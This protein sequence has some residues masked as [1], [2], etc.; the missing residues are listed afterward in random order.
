[1][2][3]IDTIKKDVPNFGEMFF[4]TETPDTYGRPQR[5]FSA[6]FVIPS[7]PRPRCIRTGGIFFVYKDLFQA[8]TNL[9]N[10]CSQ[11]KVS[12]HAGFWVLS[13]LSTII[14]IQTLN[15]RK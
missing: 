15:R 10:A 11:K 2:R 1:M 14:L 6:S 8:T 3:D 7:L 12:V 4:E 9:R 13:T 5:T